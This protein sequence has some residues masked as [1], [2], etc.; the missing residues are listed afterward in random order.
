MSASPLV[1]P[2]PGDAG[3]Q[4]IPVLCSWAYKEWTGVLDLLRS[5][6]QSILLRKGGIAE[7]PRGF[8]PDHPVFWL[9]PTQ[10]HQSE[11]GLK[12]DQPSPATEAGPETGRIPIELLAVSSHA[13]KLDRWEQ[14]EALE[15]FHAWT[16]E[17][18][19]RRFEYKSAGLWLLVTRLYQRHTPWLILD[20]VEHQG[21]K[22]WVPLEPALA[23]DGI[24]PVL[25]E[26]DWRYQIE[27][28]RQV[29][30]D[31]GGSSS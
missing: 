26:A 10:L 17:T 3:A 22:T 27:Q 21:C 25:A 2:M 20:R 11:Q 30:F 5:G 14:V 16:R 19:R 23:T 18:I 31:R 13:L 1:H 9:Y 15:P 12:H 24:S 7:G 29:L 4:E 8:L 28:I 6:R